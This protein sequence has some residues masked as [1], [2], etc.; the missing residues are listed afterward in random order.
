M[1]K[2]KND[3]EN[4]QTCWSTV[5]KPCIMKT[6]HDF[7]LLCLSLNHVIITVSCSSLLFYF[8]RGFDIT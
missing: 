5:T 2:K 6:E 7:I 3:A 1:Q 4:V 8:K